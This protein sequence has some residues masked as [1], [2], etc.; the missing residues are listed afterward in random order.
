MTS[1]S[2]LFNPKIWFELMFLVLSITPLFRSGSKSSEGRNH[3]LCIENCIWPF[4]EQRYTISNSLLFICPEEGIVLLR[5]AERANLNW[6]LHSYT[7]S[8][9]NTLLVN[10]DQKE[11]NIWPTLRDTCLIS[12]QTEK[13]DT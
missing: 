2:T 10:I 6:T 12:F 7:Q 13:G 11:T 4:W 9:T 1:S 3:L 8:P 5:I